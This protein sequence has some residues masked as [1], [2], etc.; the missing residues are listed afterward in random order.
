I[1][2]EDFFHARSEIWSQ[3][4][5]FAHITTNLT[6]AEIKEYFNDDYGRLNDRFKFYNVIHLKGESRRG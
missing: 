3:Y 6:P 1:L 2:V 5:K 4:G